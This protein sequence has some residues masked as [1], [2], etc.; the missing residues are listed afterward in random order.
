MVL[1]QW[2]RGY[3]VE[4]NDSGKISVIKAARRMSAKDIKKLPKWRL[5]MIDAYTPTYRWTTVSVLIAKSYI[6]LRITS[7][8]CHQVQ[9]ISVCCKV[10]T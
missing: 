9:D 5:N 7:G 3:A 1:Y 10:P 4:S 2:W 6:R 8:L